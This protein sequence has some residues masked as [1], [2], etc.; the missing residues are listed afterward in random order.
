M[1]V[2]VTLADEYGIRQANLLLSI[3]KSLPFVYFG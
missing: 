1:I 2:L 3:I